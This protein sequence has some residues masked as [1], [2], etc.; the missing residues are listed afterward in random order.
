MPGKYLRFEPEVNGIC[1]MD[2]SPL[3][4]V[5]FLYVRFRIG[6]VV[7]SFIGICLVICLCKQTVSQMDKPMA[8]EKSLE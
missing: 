5:V 2:K 6:A 1:L 7:F 4:D 8:A 3:G